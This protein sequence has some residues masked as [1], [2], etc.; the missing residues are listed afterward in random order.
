M[1]D[2]PKTPW[3]N[4]YYYS[5]KNTAF[6]KKVEGQSCDLYSIICLDFPDIDPI[7]S[8]GTWTFGDFGPAD[9]E[10]QK[11]SGRWYQKLQH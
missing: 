6:L 5:D 2:K 8:G 7:A 9:E 10:V 1:S 4:G 11:A 3:K